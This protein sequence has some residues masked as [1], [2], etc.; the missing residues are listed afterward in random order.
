MLKFVIF[1]LV[2]TILA[3]CA[4][5][6]RIA[7]SPFLSIKEIKTTLI[8]VPETGTPQ[9]ANLGDTLLKKHYRS[10]GSAYQVEAGTIGTVLERGSCSVQWMPL[11]FARTTSAFIARDYTSDDP[12]LDEALVCSEPL[13]KSALVD[14]ASGAELFSAPYAAPPM[15]CKSKLDDAFYLVSQQVAP[16][17]CFYGDFRL[18]IINSIPVDAVSTVQKTFESDTQRKS[19]LIY[20]GRVGDGLRFIY[21]EFYEDMARPSFTQEIQYDLAISQTIGFKSAELEI[22]EATN[23]RISYRVLNHFA[24]F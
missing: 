9:E 23:T 13:S 18:P 17:D 24:D 3:S 16:S 5:A 6:A 20:N 1:I 8:E 22:L 4:S 11:K 19:E 15:V 10:S 2:P 14:V 21:R 7:P 12:E